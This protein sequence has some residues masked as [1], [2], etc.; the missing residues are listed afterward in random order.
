MKNKTPI[1]TG[2]APAMVTAF[3]E[4]GIDFA[5]QKDIIEHLIKGGAGA[6]VV[7][8]TTGEPST[9][10]QLEREKLI[11]FS[12]K[13]VNKRVPLVAGS[14]NNNTASAIEFSKKC[15]E[16]GADAL[17]IVTPYYNKCTQAGL[18][19]HYKAIDAAVSIPIIA[20]NVPG[21]TMVN[22]RPSTAAELGKLKN[23]VA[24]KEAS[25]N[26]GQI[27]D[28]IRVAGDVLDVYSG[29]DPLT[30]PC[31]MLGAKGVISVTANAAPKKMA[32][33]AALSLQGDYKKARELH[34]ELSQLIEL[35]F[36]EVNPIPVK[37][38]TELLGF[39]TSV[40][41]LP[42]TELSSDN[43]IKLKAEMQ[44]LKLI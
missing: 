3:N 20:Y 2:C 21:R 1:F 28:V 5:A 41:R 30:Y 15:Q 17:M 26:I 7:C 32:M 25:G 16:L 27:S 11:E 4:S 14:G 29:D 13:T 8:G 31:I 6:I 19:E 34:F 10:T 36:C 35:M 38:A 42:L 18:I 37:K 33:L 12:V 22:I 39:K 40:L 9:M 43:V 23:V 44:R 24:I